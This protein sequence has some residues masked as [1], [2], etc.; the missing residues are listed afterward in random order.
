MSSDSV[1]IRINLVTQ[2][3]QTNRFL[4]L[5]CILFLTGI[6]TVDGLITLS[7][8][9]KPIP[10]RWRNQLHAG[11]VTLVTKMRSWAHSLYLNGQIQWMFQWFLVNVS[12]QAIWNWFNSSLNSLPHIK[13]TSIIQRASW[14]F[15]TEH[16]S[17]ICHSDAQTK[18]IYEYHKIH[19]L[20]PLDTIC[21]MGTWHSSFQLLFSR[22]QAVHLFQHLFTHMI[23]IQIHFTPPI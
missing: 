10:S 14:I 2:I 19:T 13:W 21:L 15:H 6:R 9:S 20:E 17:L 7:Q 18:R 12:R 5:I 22:S 4:V 23:W 11:M 8:L 16:Y 3:G 1:W